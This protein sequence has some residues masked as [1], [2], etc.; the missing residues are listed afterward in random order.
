[1]FGVVGGLFLVLFKIGVVFLAILAVCGL[2][3][4]GALI[5][6][7]GAAPR[8]RAGLDTVGWLLLVLSSGNTLLAY[9]T[10]AAALEHWEASRVSAVIALTPLATLAFTAVA[11]AL[12]PQHVDARVVSPGALI[13]SLVVVIGSLL[14]ALGGRRVR[15]DQV[16]AR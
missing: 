1:M 5:F 15:P 4:G 6:A 14:V 3:A 9:G 8:T 7:G 16:S 11:A 12:W 10:F 13:A 2:F